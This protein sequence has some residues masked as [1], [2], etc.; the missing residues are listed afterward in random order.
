MQKS[1]EKCRNLSSRGEDKAHRWPVPT[2]KCRTRG[3]T[4]V[5]LTN[6]A[7]QYVTNAEVHGEIQKSEYQE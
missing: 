5:F 3:L 4:I 2:Q 7:E 6:N 1:T